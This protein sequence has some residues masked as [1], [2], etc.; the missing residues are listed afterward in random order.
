MS[1]WQRLTAQSRPS[2]DVA[3][4][5]LQLVLVHDRTRIPPGLLEMLKDELIAVISRHLKI[6]QDGVDV[7]LYQDGQE[8]R[9][10]ADIPILSDAEPSLQPSPWRKATRQDRSGRRR[11]GRT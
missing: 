2:R 6:D 10:V 11:S 7:R 8:S 9:L 4:E 1:L 5:R 3:K